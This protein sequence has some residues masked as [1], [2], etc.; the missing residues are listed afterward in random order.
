MLLSRHVSVRT[1]D[2]V[3]EHS[4][5]LRPLNREAGREEL[6]IADN[7]FHRPGRN[8]AEDTATAFSIS[9]RRFIRH[10]W[11][12]VVTR[13]RIHRVISLAKHPGIR[14]CRVSGVVFSDSQSG[15]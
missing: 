8:T 5:S 9:E 15:G 13:Q 3:L 6:F 11:S 1:P 4:R 12:A 10:Q 2:R 14:V 7:W